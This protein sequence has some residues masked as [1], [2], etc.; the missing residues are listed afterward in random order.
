MPRPQLPSSRE[1]AQLLQVAWPLILAQLA[2][3]SLS[4]IDTMMVGRLGEQSLA[5]I[6]I[7]GTVFFFVVFIL[8]GMILAVSP[9]VSQAIGA[10]K[11]DEASR[12]AQ[13]G[14]WLGI[15]MV[16]LPLIVFLSIDPWLIWSGQTAETAKLASRGVCP[17]CS[18]CSR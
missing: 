13:Q 4:F 12:A 8:S 6:A 14:L 16:P 3:N 7:G 11:P 5:G 9:M 18:A 1:F 17:P 10:G 2:Q 15:F